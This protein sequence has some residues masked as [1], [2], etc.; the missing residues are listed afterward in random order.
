LVLLATHSSSAYNIACCSLGIIKE[1]K[2]REHLVSRFP[3]QHLQNTK[4][5][6]HTHSL[7]LTHKHTHSHAHAP[8][9]TPL[10][11][12]PKWLQWHQ[13][14]RWRGASRW[15]TSIHCV[16]WWLRTWVGLARTI[17]IR[18]IYGIFGW[19][20]KKH[21]VIYG[22]YIIYMYMLWPTLEVSVKYR[23]IIKGSQLTVGRCVLMGCQ[24]IARR[25]S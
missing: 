5:H 9:P 8:A 1:S 14:W 2:Q 17:N 12:A 4:S 13:S 11:A 24:S 3:S 16:Q 23:P 10:P 25:L 7:K 18:C 15:G 6:T 20:N 19:E 22:I 21:T